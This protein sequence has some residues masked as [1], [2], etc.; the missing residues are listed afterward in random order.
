MLLSGMKKEEKA[1]KKTRRGKGERE[2][3][4][5]QKGQERPPSSRGGPLELGWGKIG[6][7]VQREASKKRKKE[8]QKRRKGKK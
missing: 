6:G 3:L 4:V 8:I 7:L 1:I 5:L 2:I